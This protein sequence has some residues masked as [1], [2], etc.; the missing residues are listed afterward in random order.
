MRTRVVLAVFLLYLV[1]TVA[2]TWPLALG[3][4]SS[5]PGDYWRSIAER[6]D[7]VVERAERA[8]YCAVMG[9][10]CV[11]PVTRRARLLRA[12]PR[13]HMAHVA[14]AVG[15]HGSVGGAQHRVHGVVDPR[16]RSGVDARVRLD[17]EGRRGARRQR[18]LRLA[19]YRASQVSHLQVL[20]AYWMPLA[21]AA[22]HVYMRTGAARWLV[23]FAVAWLLQGMSNG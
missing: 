1:L 23:A 11:L 7:P 17:G 8:S 5:V 15:G 22:L 18:R 21:L 19:P 20:T 14:A 16:R 4:A 9:C 10:A 6:V 13:T 12:P 3:P 2:M